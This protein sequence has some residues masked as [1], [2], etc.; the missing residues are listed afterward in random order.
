MMVGRHGGET[1]NRGAVRRFGEI[2]HVHGEPACTHLRKNEQVSTGRPSLL[3]NCPRP[4]Q[5]RH[6]VMPAGV[7]LAKSDGESVAWI[8]SFRSQSLRR[9]DASGYATLHP[10]LLSV[11]RPLSS[12]VSHPPL[13]SVWREPRA[14]RRTPVADSRG[15]RP[16]PTGRSCCS[17]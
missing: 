13:Q 14:R 3:R 10:P 4:G 15:T 16:T 7:V 9:A 1:A 2:L 5:R 6:W 17:R 12:S 8:Q 11:S